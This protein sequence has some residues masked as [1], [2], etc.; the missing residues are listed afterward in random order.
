MPF[1]AFGVVGAGIATVNG[2]RDV[3]QQG[4]PIDAFEREGAGY[5]A[6]VTGTAFS[7]STAVF[8]LVP[9]PYVGA[10]VITFGSV[11]L[12]AEVW[13]AW[14]DEIASWVGDR[15]GEHVHLLAETASAAWD[16]GSTVF[17]TTSSATSDAFD[18]AT[19]G[20]AELAG[21]IWDAGAGAIDD[22]GRAFEGVFGRD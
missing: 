13:D 22:I 3:W 1:R 20:A 21:D 14:G 18:R 19:E 8:I 12:G 4:N 17:T 6:D 11:W 9:H 16:A 2:A 10:V 5:V 7:A 15:V